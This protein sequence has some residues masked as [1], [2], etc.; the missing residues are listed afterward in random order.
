MRLNSSALFLIGI[1]F[2]LVIFW[3]CSSLFITGSS[4][5]SFLTILN[6]FK[7]STHYGYIF[8]FTYSFIP[9]CGSLI[10]FNISKKWGFLHDTVGKAVF[11]FSLSLFSW[12]IGEFVWSY[13]NFFLN[14][15]IPYPSWSDVGF[16]LN[17]P[18]W[19]IGMIYFG[20]AS[21][22]N[23]GLHK[24]SRK[25]LLILIPV[26]VSLVSWYFLVILAR[27]GSITS[28]GGPL[29]VF[30]DIAYPAGDVILLTMGLLIFGLS[31][32]YWS[33]QLK[34]PIIVIL[35]GILAE[36]ISDFYFSYTTTI[37]T[38]YNGCLGDLSFA[39]ALLILSVGVTLLDKR[40]DPLPQYSSGIPAVQSIP[41]IPNLPISSAMPISSPSAS[42]SVAQPL[43]NTPS[44]TVG[45]E[46]IK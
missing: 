40:Q 46:T 5:I 1:Y 9:F 8:A 20:K 25:I 2:T 31:F 32:R 10:G 38:F 43:S 11:F 28:G 12:A 45:Q 30:F 6:G 14:S 18:L 41:A 22:A 13:Y 35:V 16:V 24:T 21:G 4:H 44:S 42:P 27:G 33:D 17:Y 29:K 39:T 7:N 34:W 19:G 15:N 36:Y 26:L 37:N 23:I 3:L